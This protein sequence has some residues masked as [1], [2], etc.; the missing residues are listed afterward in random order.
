MDE[1][2]QEEMGGDANWEEGSNLDGKLQQFWWIFA[3]HLL[4]MSDADL[5]GDFDYDLAAESKQDVNLVLPKAMDSHPATVT[6]PASPN[7]GG[8]EHGFECGVFA[9]VS[10]R[11]KRPSKVDMDGLRKVTRMSSWIDRIVQVAEQSTLDDRE[12]GHQ[13]MEWLASG[14]SL[15]KEK[16]REAL[17]EITAK[18]RRQILIDCSLET[19]VPVWQGA[20]KKFVSAANRLTQFIQQ[21]KSA[22]WLE[23]QPQDIQQIVI[24]SVVS[25]GQLALEMGKNLRIET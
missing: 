20:R 23:D 11:K 15:P 7:M 10:P 5:F 16:V 13:F 8:H 17:T 22:E 4:K 14:Q 6:P 24:G 2:L 1:G 12:G 18:V 25:I 19:K 3:H 9:V 21:R